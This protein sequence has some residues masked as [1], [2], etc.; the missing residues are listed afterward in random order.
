MLYEMEDSKDMSEKHSLFERYYCNKWVQGMTV[1]FIHSVSWI[2]VYIVTV[3]F[4]EYIYDD[5]DDNVDDNDDDDG[6]DDD[7]DDD[8]NNNDDVYNDD[9]GS[10]SDLKKSK[11]IVN[12]IIESIK[13]SQ[14]GWVL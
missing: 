8:D 9:L 2:C 3:F 1:I 5:V 4:C 12:N 14:R 7:D 13:L 6:N 11:T 10:K